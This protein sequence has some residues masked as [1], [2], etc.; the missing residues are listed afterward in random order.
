MFCDEIGEFLQ[1][2]A[3]EDLD[4][5]PLQASEEYESTQRKHPAP[6]PELPHPQ[7]CTSRTAATPLMLQ[8]LPLQFGREQFPT[9]HYKIQSNVYI[10]G[11]TGGPTAKRK[12]G[13]TSHHCKNCRCS[14]G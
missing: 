7:Q 10:S 12:Q 9:G 2:H 8:P 14:I 5:L 4:S 3:E 13:Q 11:M 6:L 1:H